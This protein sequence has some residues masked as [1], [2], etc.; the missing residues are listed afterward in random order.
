MPTLYKLAVLNSNQKDLIFTYDHTQ[1]R[2]EMYGIFILCMLLTSIYR[3]FPKESHTYTIAEQ[4]NIAEML[5]NH[6]GIKKAHVLSHDY[7][8]TVA[9]ELLARFVPLTSKL[10][11]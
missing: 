8:D 7:G 4:A 11:T 6:L 1:T 10:K 5:I 2:K 3:M 9:L